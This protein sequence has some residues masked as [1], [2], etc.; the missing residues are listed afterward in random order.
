[1]IFSCIEPGWLRITQR[2]SFSTSISNAGEITPGRRACLEC[3]AIMKFL[4]LL[5][6]CLI[7]A[8]IPCA[9]RDNTGRVLF[10]PKLAVGQ[11][12]R[13]QIGY[14]AKSSMD[15]RKHRGR[16]HGSG[17][18][19]DQR[20]S[21]SACRGGRL[22]GRCWQAGGA[23]AHAN[24]RA[25]CCRRLRDD[26]ERHQNPDASAKS[27]APEK[28]VEFILH[29][30]GQV[31]DVEG[32]DRLSPDEQTAWREWVARFGGSAS[33]P[34]KN[35]KPGE[36]WK[37]EEPISRRVARRPFLGKR[38]GICERCAL[39]RDEDHRARRSSNG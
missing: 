28:A 31:T 2:S 11:T 15:D 7:L 33:S 39:R 22:G 14:S 36:K 16:A 10:F 26:A 20:K 12:F 27:A 19:P 37:S 1:M 25:G 13:Y 24:P 3:V 17:R 29:A 38:I 23:S 34:E 5:G 32:L 18:R 8:A 6:C 30:D 35:M 4:R 9:A 21:S